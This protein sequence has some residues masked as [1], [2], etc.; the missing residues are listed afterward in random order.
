MLGIKQSFEGPYC[1]RDNFNR[2]TSASDLVLKKTLCSSSVIGGD[3]NDHLH[4]LQLED[5]L[6]I[7]LD[8]VAPDVERE[9]EGDAHAEAGTGQQQDSVMTLSY[10]IRASVKAGSDASDAAVESYRSGLYN[11]LSTAILLTIPFL[12]L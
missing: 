3:V 8:S 12:I 7:A 6:D 10:S 9:G 2:N 11:T 5:I 4:P 1:T